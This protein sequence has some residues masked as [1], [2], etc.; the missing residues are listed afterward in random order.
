MY[1]IRLNRL[2]RRKSLRGSLKNQSLHGLLTNWTEIVKGPGLQIRYRLVFYLFFTISLDRDEYVSEWTLSSFVAY[3]FLFFRKSSNENTTRVSGVQ[4]RPNDNCY[5]RP[6]V[7]PPH[8]P[9]ESAETRVLWRRLTNRDPNQCVPY[10]DNYL[11]SFP[12]LYAT[13]GR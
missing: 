3:F 7:P 1:S 4:N 9:T 8:W 11:H 13:R 6:R 10:G 2:I 5:F 12:T